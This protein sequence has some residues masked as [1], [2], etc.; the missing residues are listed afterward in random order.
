MPKSDE[1]QQAMRDFYESMSG[2][3]LPRFA[4]QLSTEE[5]V[6]VIGTD[7]DDWKAGREDWIAAHERSRKVGA[8]PGRLEPGDRLAGYSE[9][10]IGWAADQANMV[11]GDGSRVPVRVTAL[12]RNEHGG[13]KVFNLHVSLGVPD[14][15][16]EELLPEL[17]GGF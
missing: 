3:D 5:E 16:L 10:L 13:W 17:L 1:V 14:T 8:D 7:W 11:L 15:K 4:S 2:S 12:F 9:G 6:L